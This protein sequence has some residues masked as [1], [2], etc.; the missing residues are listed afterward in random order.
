MSAQPPW[1]STVRTYDV[2]LLTGMVY[3]RSSSLSAS[4][5]KITSYLPPKMVTV[6]VLEGA[7]RAE[8]DADLGVQR[9][10]RIAVL[11][12]DPV[13][14]Q[15]VVVVEHVEE[16]ATLPD[17]HL[18]DAAPPLAHDPGAVLGGEQLTLGIPPVDLGHLTK[19]LARQGEP[20]AAG[21]RDQSP[22][23]SSGR[24]SGRA[25]RAAAGDGMVRQG[26]V[27][28]LVAEGIGATSQ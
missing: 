23:K 16:L 4:V 8:A 22:G 27:A 9:H 6:R 1:S 11:A 26:D 19:L 20:V 17:R 2:G 10:R 12:A 14:Q 28:R 18:A 21:G 13:A 25:S 7:Q 15:L 24:S 5:A 3:S